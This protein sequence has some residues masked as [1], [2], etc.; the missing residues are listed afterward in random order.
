MFFRTQEKYRLESRGICWSHMYLHKQSALNG[1]H[2]WIMHSFLY[3]QIISNVQGNNA[4]SNFI[5]IDT[6]HTAYSAI[7]SLNKIPGIFNLT[8]MW[9]GV[10]HKTSENIV[11]LK[12]FYLKL[13]LKSFEN[14]L[15]IILKLFL[16][17]SLIGSIGSLTTILTQ[18]KQFIKL[19]ISDDST[20]TLLYM[21]LDIVW[22]S[23]YPF[24]VTQSHFCRVFLRVYFFYTF[25]LSPFFVSDAFCPSL[26][27]S[28]SCSE[29]D[30]ENSQASVHIMNLYDK[31]F[32]PNMSY[33]SLDKC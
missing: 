24:S 4:Y 20:S 33:K 9:S 14:T 1:F 19:Y 27:I 30:E 16:K 11:L 25:S 31:H 21:I 2:K 29:K 32:G 17:S 23:C 15:T 7:V 18:Q 22:Q 8:I 10:L 12:M 3:I 13:A 5:T 26:T 6:V 28:F